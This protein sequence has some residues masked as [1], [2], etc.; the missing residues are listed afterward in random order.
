MNRNVGGD[1]GRNYT[2][3]NRINKSN[4]NRIKN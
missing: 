3:N 4:S 2:E 1:N